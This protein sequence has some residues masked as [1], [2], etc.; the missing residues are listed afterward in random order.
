MIYLS[1]FMQK[2]KVSPRKLLSSFGFLALVGFVAL[3]IYT[4]YILGTDNFHQVGRGYVYRSAQLSSEDLGEKVSQYG[5][6]SVL[7][8]RG[9]NLDKDWYKQEIAFCKTHGIQHYDLSL[10]AG[11]DV[12]IAQMNEIVTILKTAQKP[13]LLH[14]LNGADRSALASSLYRFAIE[15]ESAS[16]ADDELT[17]WYGHIPFITPHVA[18]MD[19][20]FSA[21]VENLKI[22]Q[23]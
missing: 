10:S 4:I 7:N 5:I 1:R 19:R 23:L 8:L 22:N 6:R 11:H 13:I 20:S 14:C 15:K 12:S 17:M 3:G 18:A 2:L 9:Q 16:E 21:Y